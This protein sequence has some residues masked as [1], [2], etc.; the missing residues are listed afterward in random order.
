MKSLQKIFMRPRNILMIRLVMNENQSIK[1]KFYVILLVLVML[2]GILTLSPAI[3]SLM[4]TYKL[5]ESSGTIV[6]NEAYAESGSVEDVQAAV[7]AVVAAGGG[8]VYIPEGDFTFEPRDSG[9][10]GPYGR[11]TGV[12]FVVP[13]AGINIFGGGKG[14]TVLEMPVDDIAPNVGMF[15]VTGGYETARAVGGWISGGKLRISGITFKG[16]S[17]IDTSPSGDHAILLVSV[18]DFRIDN[19]EFLCMGSVGIWV[20]DQDTQYSIVGGDPDRITQGVVD[21]SD[22]ID[23]HKPGALAAGRGYGYGIGIGRA[24]YWE[25]TYWEDD[26][27]ELFGKYEGNIFVEDCYFTRCRHAVAAS[28][29]G[30]Y[31]LRNSVIEDIAIFASATTGHPNRATYFGMLAQEIYNI[32]IRR[33]PAGAE[34]NPNNFFGILVEGG[35]ALLYNNTFDSCYRAFDISACESTSGR[36]DTHPRGHTKEVYIWDN[37]YINLVTTFNI[38]AQDCPA[39]VE[40]VEYF[41]HAP[42]AEKNYQPYSY[43]HPL[44]LG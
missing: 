25:W 11:P 42:S 30:T 10:T 36:G 40:G 17:N 6:A 34:A 39:P 31:V 19:C 8:T 38:F 20:Q 1:S 21:H 24:M 32:T 26:P 3:S 16:R 5:V 15:C 28:S 33:T 27:W 14:V 18:R 2:T 4:N 13:A 43:P 41:L 22:F 35:S 44:T 12:Q 23:M 37:T 7:D 9:L 29:G